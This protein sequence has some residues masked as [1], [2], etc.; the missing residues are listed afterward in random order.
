MKL[1]DTEIK[2]IKSSTKPFK[3]SDGVLLFLWV[4]PPG[5]KVWRWAYRHEGR[6]KL[7]T[8][9]KCPDVSLAIAREHAPA[10]R[11][12]TSSLLGSLLNH[13]NRVAEETK[14]GL[15]RLSCAVKS[16]SDVSAPRTS[17]AK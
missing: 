13:L 3:A 12:S 10:T 16:E 5:G 2:R 6:A 7:M 17:L 11:R 4:T 8:F 14:D 9:G 1:T 15:R